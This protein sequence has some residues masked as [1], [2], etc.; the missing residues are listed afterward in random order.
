MWVFQRWIDEMF[1]KEIL[2]VLPAFDGV[3][4]VYKGDLFDVLD[5]LSKKDHIS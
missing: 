5:K 4:E 2:F 1:S 3:G